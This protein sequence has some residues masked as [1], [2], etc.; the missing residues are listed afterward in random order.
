MSGEDPYR[1]IQP[2]DLISLMGD[3]KVYLKTAQSYQDD[4]FDRHERTGR[5]LG[6]EKF[7]EKA[8]RFLHRDL[9]KKKPGPKRHDD[10]N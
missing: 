2:Q 7:I 10:E 3:W 4:E 6:D 5:P 1:M 8:E 9:K